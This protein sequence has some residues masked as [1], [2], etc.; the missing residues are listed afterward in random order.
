MVPMNRWNGHMRTRLSRNRLLFVAATLVSCGERD[1]LIDPGPPL[2]THADEVCPSPTPIDC[3]EVRLTDGPTEPGEGRCEQSTDC[4]PSSACI[5]GTC[6]RFAEVDV[7]IC[8]HQT[9]F[10]GPHCDGLN[11]VHGV[12]LHSPQPGDGIFTN[13][14]FSE[15]L[16]A[17]T[18]GCA[19]VFPTDRSC[20]AVNLH[21]LIYDGMIAGPYLAEYELVAGNFKWGYPTHLQ[22]HAGT[23]TQILERLDAGCFD[24]PENSTIGH[25]STLSIWGPQ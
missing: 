9:A 18:P 16:W 5:A 12:L 6:H 4:H 11:F 22:W 23:R 8:V 19:V 15:F 17:D 20:F 13:F 7:T 3:P 14:S 10:V 2:E 1:R 24:V 25:R 21:D